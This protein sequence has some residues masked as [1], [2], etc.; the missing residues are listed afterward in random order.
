[1]VSEA[2]DG[3]IPESFVE[4]VKNALEH[5]YDLSHLQRHPLAREAGGAPNDE[6]GGLRLRREL[7]QAVERLAAQHSPASRATPRSRAWQTCCGCT[8]WRA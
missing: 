5:L 4:Q 1:M 3:A 2:D 7:M 8:I 6:A